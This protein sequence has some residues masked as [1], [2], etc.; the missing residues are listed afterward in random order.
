MLSISVHSSSRFDSLSATYAISPPPTVMCTDGF[1]CLI[2]R[3]SVSAGIA[4]L[5]KVIESPTR[6]GSIACKRGSVCSRKN[7]M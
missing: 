6:S 5:G 3:A 4:W 1:H 7:S 2:R